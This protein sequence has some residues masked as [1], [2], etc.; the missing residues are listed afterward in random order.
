MKFGICVCVEDIGAAERAGYDYVELTVTNVAP[1]VGKAE[2]A[3]LKKR[4]GGFSIRPEAWRRFL[5][6]ELR[7]V[8]GEVDFANVTDYVRTTMGRIGE[9]GGKV[10]VFGSPGARNIPEGFP[11]Q[12]AHQQIVRFLQMTADVAAE[13]DIT[14]VIEPIL[15]RNCNVI[16]SV[17]EAVALASEL[18]RP[19]VKVLADLYHMTADGEPLNVI[20]ETHGLLRHVHMP[21]PD[22]SGLSEARNVTTTL[23]SYP[24]EGLLK[25][26]REIDYTYTM[27]VEDLD[28][29]FMNLEREAP[30][31]LSHIRSTWEGFSSLSPRE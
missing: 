1:E 27:S 25:K 20:T 2:I 4:L 23:P 3:N 31:V 13:N 15:R 10:V 17:S 19:E 6:G 14:V 30:L 21:V 22:I 8:G 7:L 5:P 16:N 28:R 18:G 29:R 9:L 11:R 12:R 24:V 26:L